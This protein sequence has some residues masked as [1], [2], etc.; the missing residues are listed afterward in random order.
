MHVLSTPPAFILSQDQT[1][2]FNVCLVRIK[3]PTYL[4]VISIAWNYGYYFFDDFSSVNWL[5]IL[6]FSFQ[7]SFMFFLCHHLTTFIS[8]LCFILFVNIFFEIFK[9]LNFSSLLQAF[10][11]IYNIISNLICQLS[12]NIFLIQRWIKYFCFCDV[13]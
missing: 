5:Y 8:I 6:L 10:S 7:G 2:K 1:L 4:F 12:F 13:Y 11:L 9:I 3:H